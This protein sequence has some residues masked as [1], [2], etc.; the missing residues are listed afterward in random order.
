MALINDPYDSKVNYFYI[1]SMVYNSKTIYKFGI[2]NNPDQ[3]VRT[4]RTGNPGIKIV[5]TYP[6]D[7]K[8]HAQL[9]ETIIHKTFEL[10][11]VDGPQKEWFNV[12]ESVIDTKFATD[13]F[14]NNIE[15]IRRS[16]INM[17]TSP[18]P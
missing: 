9:V 8:M 16:L 4:F 12:P 3:R 1:M 5:K 13:E 2:S 18:G 10:Y 6:F 17:D 14:K 7:C 15:D 11:R